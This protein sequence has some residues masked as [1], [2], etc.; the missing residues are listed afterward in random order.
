MSGNEHAWH[1]SHPTAVTAKLDD[2]RPALAGKFMTRRQLNKLSLW[3]FCL[4]FGSGF[5]S[6][7]VVNSPYLDGFRP[8]II[9]F[10][11]LP[12]GFLGI[13]LIIFEKWSKPNNSLGS[14]NR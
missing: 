11:M 14:R 2:F 7:F 3:G 12:V 8:T 5:G 1:G 13:A 6:L 4:I 10:L 9:W